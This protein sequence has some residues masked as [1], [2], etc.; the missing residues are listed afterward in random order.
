MSDLANNPSGPTQRGFSWYVKF[1]FACYA[2]SFAVFL[3]AVVVGLP[4]GGFAL[5]EWWFTPAGNLAMFAI[6]VAVSPFMYRW[7]R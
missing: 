4:F 7:L 2:A 5:A 3:L 6:A 1:V